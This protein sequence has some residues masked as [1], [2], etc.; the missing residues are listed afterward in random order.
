MDSRAFLAG[1]YEEHKDGPVRSI[2]VEAVTL[3]EER[4][5]DGHHKLDR[6]RAHSRGLEQA[7]NAGRRPRRHH[8]DHRY[9]DGR[10]HRRGVRRGAFRRR[11][12]HGTEHLV[13]P[14]GHP[15]GDH[16]TRPLPPDRGPQN[17]LR[18]R[19]RD[20]TG[21]PSTDET[22]GCLAPADR[23]PRSPSCAWFSSPSS[24]SWPSPASRSPRTPPVGREYAPVD[25]ARRRPLPEE[26]RRRDQAIMPPC[27]WWTGTRAWTSGRRSSWG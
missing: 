20:E 17:D 16:T 9:R 14:R 5:G 26:N 8:R 25:G 23:P 2:P 21:R 6:G 3:R 4:R 12:G 19:R 22:P 7:G 18:F 1:I 24:G 27:S 11:R 15:W 10:G 13:H